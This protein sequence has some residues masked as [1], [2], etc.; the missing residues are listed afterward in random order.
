MRIKL[1]KKFRLILEVDEIELSPTNLFKSEDGVQMN[2]NV[3]IKSN[4]YIKSVVTPESI[5]EEG[6]VTPEATE[7][8]PTDLTSPYLLETPTAVQYVP[9]SLIDA[10][11]YADS[12]EDEATKEA[13]LDQISQ[14][15]DSAGY[16]NMFTGSLEGM[17]LDIK[18]VII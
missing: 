15:V 17:R 6:V 8:V 13:V 11:V 9:K 1:K 3:A 12:I 18:D 14:Q 10:L 7:E 5:N 4:T 16:N 2:V